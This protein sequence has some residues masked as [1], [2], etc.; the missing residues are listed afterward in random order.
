MNTEKLEKRLNDWNDYMSE[1]GQKIR[2]FIYGFLVGTLFMT[3]SVI[4]IQIFLK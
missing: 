3:L 2:Y 4:I 1:N